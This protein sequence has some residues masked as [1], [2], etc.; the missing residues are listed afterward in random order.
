[1]SRNDKQGIP[2]PASCFIYSDNTTEVLVMARNID[3]RI[4]ELRREG[5]GY[6]AIAMS[7]GIDR[8]RVRYVCRRHGLAGAMVEAETYEERES[9]FK[10]G[11]EK[12]FPTF[13]YLSGFQNQDSPFYCKCRTCGHI[14]ERNAQCV[15]PSRHKELQCDNCNALK[16][17]RQALVDV[18]SKRRNKM[19]R[20]VARRIK[21]REARKRLEYKRLNKLKGYICK[22]CGQEF[23]ATHGSQKYCTQQ[24]A[25]K[26]S[27]RRKE[28][29][30]RRKLRKNGPIHWSISLDKLSKRDKNI[31]HICGGKCDWQDYEISEAGHF[32]VGKNYPSTDHIVPVAD[33]GT[34]TW[35]NVRLAHHYCNTV[36]SSSRVYVGAGGQL[37]L[38]V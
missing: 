24:C 28:I 31:C 27:G 23:N 12:K 15:R 32:I 19:A 21:R 35:D 18:L 22:E 29:R 8:D 20:R 9:R 30:R 4:V 2:N 33:G 13:E 38:A 36:K 34:H 1:M 17:L 7:L 11:F 6:R 14:Q 5:K 37:W 16:P 3:S 25:D 26:A 10:R